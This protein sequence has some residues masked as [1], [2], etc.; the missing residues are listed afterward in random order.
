[1][2]NPARVRLKKNAN[3][4]TAKKAMK[5]PTLARLGGRMYLSSRL[6]SS[7]AVCCTPAPPYSG[8]RHKY[9]ENRVAT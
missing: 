9:V 8:Y 1:M 4:M 2:K 6:E 5:I 3:A 7:F